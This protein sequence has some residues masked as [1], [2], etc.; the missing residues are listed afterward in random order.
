MSENIQPI[1]EVFLPR[2]QG[3]FHLLRNYVPSFTGA[4][5]RESLRVDQFNG[6]DGSI[7]LRY[8]MRRGGRFWG[9]PCSPMLEFRTITPDSP[10][11]VTFGPETT[12]KSERIG[13]TTETVDNRAGDGDVEVDFS[14]LFSKE[15]SKET[16]HDKSA[17]GSVKV[18]IES[19]QD[20]EGI[21]S[22]KEAVE[23]EAHA[24]VSE[25]TAT[26]SSTGK[27][28]TGDEGTIVKPGHCK[29]ITE[30]RAR[31]DTRQTVTAEGA[32]SFAFAAGQYTHDV[33][34]KHH[35]IWTVWESWQQ[36]LDCVNGDAPDNYP[37]ADSFQRRPIEH[38][39]R[40]A[41]RM[42][43][44]PLRYDVKF[45]GKVIRSFAVRDCPRDDA[46]PGAAG[47]GR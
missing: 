29:V 12:L 21:A 7:T 1:H 19:E 17:G 46:V 45:E 27:E 34:R 15:D 25:S 37:M 28:D 16:S 36:F 26:S 41:L 30:T 23:T 4:S 5:S 9:H 18:S 32:F 3:L 10:E 6:S 47:R 40:W 33:E 35:W 11:S 31:A 22:F 8:T 13:A 14:D 42:L 43:N 39:D 44:V 24:E 20:V 38:A 2:A